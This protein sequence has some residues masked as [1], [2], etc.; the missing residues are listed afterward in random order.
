M[1][2]EI[3]LQRENFAQTYNNSTRKLLENLQKNEYILQTN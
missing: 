2:R 1:F 3:A